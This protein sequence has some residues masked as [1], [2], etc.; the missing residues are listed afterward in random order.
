MRN[1]SVISI[2]PTS[3]EGHAYLCASVCALFRCESFQSS[4]GRCVSDAHRSVMDLMSC[5]WSVN[6]WMPGRSAPLLLLLVYWRLLQLA[7]RICYWYSVDHREISLWRRMSGMWAVVAASTA[8]AVAAEIDGH[9]HQNCQ[10]FCCSEFRALRGRCENRVAPTVVE[11]QPHHIA[12]E[13]WD[14]FAVVH[15]DWNILSNVLAN[16]QY[17]RGIFVCGPKYLVRSMD[18]LRV[19]HW[20]S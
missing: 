15:P 8:V 12:A 11:P 17:H 1:A 5:H 16:L 14:R 6:H 2:S 7:A 9:H 18:F 19:T 20:K 4:S 10:T 3:L 13:D